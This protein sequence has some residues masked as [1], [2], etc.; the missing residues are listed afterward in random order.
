MRKDSISSK[1]NKNKSPELLR[2]IGKKS[3]MSRNNC[4]VRIGLGTIVS[5]TRLVDLN[6][7][8]ICRSIFYK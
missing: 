8:Y 5:R 1:A 3:A 6:R 2:H 4:C 7:K